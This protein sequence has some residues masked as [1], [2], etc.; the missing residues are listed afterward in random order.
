MNIKNG[1]CFF[2]VTRTLP[3]VNQREG[4]SKNSAEPFLT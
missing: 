1:N 3:D 4:V 2:Y